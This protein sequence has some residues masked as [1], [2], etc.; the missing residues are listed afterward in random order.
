MKADKFSQIL[1]FRMGKQWVGINIEQVREVVTRQNRTI[2]PLAPGFV[3]GLI[4]LRGRIVT[5]LDVRAVIEPDSRPD[6]ADI[7][8]I[9]D[10]ARRI[11]IIEGRNS[12]GFGLLVDAVGEV[13]GFD[14]NH[15]ESTPKSIPVTWQKVCDG[16][17][18]QDGRVLLLMN[19]DQF[20]ELTLEKQKLESE[21]A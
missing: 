3:L 15:Y 1:T 16:V 18:K 9:A 2:M 6:I 20:L 7:A 14:A 5:E 13:T 17:L 19:V 11:L 12:E 10:S 21:A 8:D 4:N